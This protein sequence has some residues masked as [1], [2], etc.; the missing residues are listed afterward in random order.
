MRIGCLEEIAFGNGWIGR[1]ELNR[2][3]DV[4][5]KSEY[6]RYLRELAART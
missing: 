3:A 4:Q 5:A 2:Q 1:D 6:G